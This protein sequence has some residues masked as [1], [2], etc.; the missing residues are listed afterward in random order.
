MDEDTDARKEKWLLP[1]DT[2]LGFKAWSL[3]IQVQYLPG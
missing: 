3:L 2:Q 1:N